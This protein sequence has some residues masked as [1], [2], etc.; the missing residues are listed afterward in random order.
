MAVNLTPL[1]HA[2]TA[3]RSALVPA[4]V[5][6]LFINALALVSPIYM[7]QVYDRVLASRNYSTLLF[8]TLI[9]IFLFLVYGALEALRSRVLI[10][11]GARFENVLRAPLFEAAF[12]ATLGRK[13]GSGESQPFRDADTVREFLTGSAIFAFFDMPWVP[14][15]IAASFLL[16]PIFGWLAI[17]AGVIVFVIAVANEYW[18]RTSLNRATQ[19]SMSAHAD[20]SATLRNAEVMRAMGMAPGLQDR[21]GARRDDQIAWQAVASGRG[22]SLMAGMRTFR[23]IVQLFILGLGGYLCIEGE[24]SAGGIVA[25]SII[26]GRALAP[27]E[28]AV[29]QWKNFQNSRGAWKRLQELFR[30]NVQGQQR[31]PLPPP[32]GKLKFEQVVAVPPGSRTAVLRGIS[33]DLEKGK[34]LAIIGP[35]A[36]GKSS[37]IRVLLGVWPAF[38]PN[39]LGPYVGYLPQD[40]ELFAGSVAQNIARFRQADHADVIRA[41]KLAGVHDMVQQMPDGYDTEIGDGGQSLSG[42]QRQ[43]IGL[44]R[45][46][47][48]HPT[49]V[50][51]DEP[52]ANLDSPGEI[53]LIEAIRQLKAAGTTVAFV[54]HKTSMLTLADKVLVMDQ[55]AIRLYG[56]REE[57]M[58]KI[59]GGPKV[60][61]TPQPYATI[62]AQAPAATG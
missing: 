28:G 37:L 15:F 32:Q 9:A 33:F 11:G 4:G 2:V 7:L 49:I 44:A 42:G 38:D 58:A 41:A 55:G 51:L 62:G 22:S 8:L 16:H 18:T 48:G 27:I 26:V 12:A 53:A 43:R 30:S 57:V 17:G 31:M 50:V 54:T 29:A 36:A 47:F 25:A 61:P 60:V 6:S 14:L 20:V 10:R 52:N 23:Q 35:S 19:A 13:G 1:N 45:A 56:E 34:T 39:N 5:F 46:L 3:V 59:F 21:W 24:L 40:V